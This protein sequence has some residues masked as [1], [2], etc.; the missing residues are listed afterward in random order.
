MLDPLYLTH[1]SLAFFALAMTIVSLWVKRSPWIWGPFLILAFALAYMAKVVGSDA[2]IPIG[3]LL[4]LHTILKGDLRGLARFILVVIAIVVSL[5]LA[6]HKFPGFDNPQ[7][8]DKVKI[9]KNAYPFSLSLNFDTPFMGLF[10]LALGFPL[11]GSIR[12]FGRLLKVA[13]PL[14]IG[15]MAILIVLSLYWG[16]IA[17]DPKIP[18]IFW[19]F[20]IQNL[21]FTCVIEEAFW[22][23]FVQRE[24]FRWFGNRGFLA[25]I[26][27]VFVTAFF[28]AALHYLWI[29]N[30]PF[31]GLVFIA[32]II[33]GSIYQYTQALEAS[34]LCHWLFNITHMLLFTYPAISH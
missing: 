9:S 12:E 4:V 22:R 27:C 33:Y 29:P 13:L 18:R 14:S 25:N 24:F 23:G 2:L 31:L 32:G 1:T 3:A 30:I 11:I 8:L 16:M 17:W 21:L 28:F 5:G 26:G 15:G 20:L 19:F 10:V 7:I 34:I 6:L